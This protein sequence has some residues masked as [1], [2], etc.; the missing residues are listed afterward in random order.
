MT[1][2]GQ[3]DLWRHYLETGVIP[4]FPEKGKYRMWDKAW[5]P[6]GYADSPQYRGQQP[7]RFP[8][9]WAPAMCFMAGADGTD[10]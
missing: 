10:G 4:D 7:M 2:E 8:P 1:H 9:D 5:N 3:P 6:A